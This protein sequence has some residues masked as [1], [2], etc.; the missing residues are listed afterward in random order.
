MSEERTSQPVQDSELIHLA[1]KRLERVAEKMMRFEY[2]DELEKQIQLV[3]ELVEWAGY[4][5]QWRQ[6]QSERRATDH[7]NRSD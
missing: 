3:A 5:M 7:E 6:E 4:N 1:I 2:D